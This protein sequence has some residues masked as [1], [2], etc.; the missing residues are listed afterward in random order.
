MEISLNYLPKK[1]GEVTEAAVLSV[2]AVREET[3]LIPWGD[4][5]R[6]DL[7]IERMGKFLRIQC[8]TGKLEKGGV[9]F[10]CASSASWNTGKGAKHYVEQADLFG[11]YCPQNQKVY[12]IP[13]KG[14]GKRMCFLRIDPTK[15][16]QKKNIRWARDYEIGTVSSNLISHP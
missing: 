16:N 15:N 1:I 11:V 5:L 9:E 13:V 12:L 2:L 6:Y 10:A 14:V 4:S 3:V 8:K 7:V